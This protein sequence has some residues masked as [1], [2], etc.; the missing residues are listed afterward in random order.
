M[1][2]IK[3][4]DLGVPP[5][6]ETPIYTCKSDQKTEAATESCPWTMIT[7]RDTPWRCGNAWAAPRMEAFFSYLQLG[8]VGIYPLVQMVVVQ[9]CS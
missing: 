4:D 5:F 9:S 1:D 7:L 8:S 3:I 6:L 2:A